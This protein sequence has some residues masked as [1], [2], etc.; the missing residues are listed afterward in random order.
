MPKSSSATRKPT[1]CRRRMVVSACSG[2]FSATA[3]VNST[4][5]RWGEMS[6]RCRMRTSSSTK[7]GRANCAADTF[8]ATT[9]GGRPAASQARNCCATCSTTQKSMATMEPL[10]SAIGMNSAGDTSP[11]RGCRQRSSASAPASA[12]LPSVRW[13]W[14][15][16]NSSPRCAASLRPAASS[17]ERCVCACISGAKKR[18]PLRPSCLTRY[19]ATSAADA[20]VLAVRA[21]S[22]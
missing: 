13:G 21:S 3:S 12:P 17:S 9:S 16:R 18:S 15:T 1:S 14:N 10:C 4:S 6:M 7:C 22:G 8:T 20:K 19:I 2:F 11:Q 5:M